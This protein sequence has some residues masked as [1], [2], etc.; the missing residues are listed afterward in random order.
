MLTPQEVAE[1]HISA[2]LGG[3]PVLMAADYAYDAVLI[4]GD[5]IYNGKDE[6][7]DYFKSVPERL[8]N[9]RLEFT[10]FNVCGDEA[11]FSWQIVGDTIKASGQDVLVISDGLIIKQEVFLSNSDF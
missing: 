1:Q 9:D 6:I 4:R 11:T 3:D 8:G 5:K 10:R 2:V 7:L